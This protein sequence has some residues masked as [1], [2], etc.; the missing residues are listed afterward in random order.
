[1]IYSVV[2]KI[3]YDERY[4]IGRCI[5]SLRVAFNPSNPHSEWNTRVAAGSALALVGAALAT[6]Y[7]SLPLGRSVALAS[8]VIAVLLPVIRNVWVIILPHTFWAWDEIARIANEKCHLALLGNR[9]TMPQLFSN[10]TWPSLINRGEEHKDPDE[11]WFNEYAKELYKNPQFFELLIDH[12]PDTTILGVQL[13]S[14]WP[15]SSGTWKLYCHRD[16][17]QAEIE[18]KGFTPEKGAELICVSRLLTEIA[19]KD[20]TMIHEGDL[21]AMGAKLQSQRSPHYKYGFALTTSYWFLRQKVHYDDPLFTSWKDAYNNM[22]EDLAPLWEHTDDG[23]FKNW[24]PKD[25]SPTQL[26]PSVPQPS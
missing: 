7:R 26:P 24:H 6:R 16:R 21:K 8:G 23:R 20:L 10:Y 12:A 18:E 11:T 1:M 4:S 14:I 19:F 25:E 22:C 9:T 13:S 2:S 5:K 17:L 3:P 15:I